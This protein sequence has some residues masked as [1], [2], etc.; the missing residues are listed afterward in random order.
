MKKT[1]ILLCLIATISTFLLWLPFILNSKTL[2]IEN[3]DQSGLLRVIENYDG[4]NYLI[5]AKTFYNPE[6]IADFETDLGA[7]YFPAHLPLY[8]AVIR[9][10]DFFLPGH[11]A[12]L[13]ATL[14]ST[15]IFIFFFVKLL[16][17][18]RIKKVFFLGLIALFLPARF[19]AVR[20]I[21]APEPLFIGLILASIYYFLGQRYFLAGLFG[22]LAQL[23]K[24]PA[25]ILFLAYFIYLLYG[26]KRLAAKQLYLALIP[27]GLVLLFSFY[28]LQT[29]DFFVYFKTPRIPLYLPPFLALFKNGRWIND[30]WIE[31]IIW[32]FLIELVAIQLLF[33]HQ[34]KLLAIFALLYFLPT[35]FIL[36]RDIA[37]YSLP[38]MP[39]VII[40]LAPLL[41]K[42]AFKT[43][44][45]LM[46]VPIYL[47]S[48][49][50]LSF[51]FHPISNW[52]P[53][54]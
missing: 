21:I 49:K 32:L 25:I 52:Q 6:L 17:K 4:P 44:F 34:N 16:D 14:F 53:Y 41:E 8:P 23:T 50:F 28:Y 22:L 42:K 1:I 9:F 20:S 26:Q 51:N 29:G 48:L 15:L 47:F 12:G 11:W 10:F 19:F 43:A 3:A 30:F 2:L 35:T 33:K 36:H 45:L 24:T 38:M 37:R 39:F 5:V 40:G 7:N 13:T 46:L 54:L 18:L 27:L 31:D